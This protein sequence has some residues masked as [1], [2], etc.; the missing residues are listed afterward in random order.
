MSC[1]VC[2]GK[3]GAFSAGPRLARRWLVRAAD[4]ENPPPSLNSGG[5]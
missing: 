5:N 3:R 4:A 1:T 2:A